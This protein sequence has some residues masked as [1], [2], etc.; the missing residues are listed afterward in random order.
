MGPTGDKPSYACLLTRLPYDYEFT[1]ADLETIEWAEN[2]LIAYGY[3]N[4]RGRYDGANL[5]IELPYDLMSELLQDPAFKEIV[6][7]LDSRI[8][9]QISLDLRGLRKDVLA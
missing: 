6:K 4:V 1:E 5:R 8:K 9:G 3:A 7:K 2:L